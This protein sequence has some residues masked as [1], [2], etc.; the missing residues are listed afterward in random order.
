MPSL[1]GKRVAFGRVVSME[2][3]AA[4]TALQSLPTFQNERPVPDVTTSW[5][6][7]YQP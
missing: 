3:L 5:K 2:G 1:D 4:L 6:I 7:L